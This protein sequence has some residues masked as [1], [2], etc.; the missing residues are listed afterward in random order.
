MTATS[1]TKLF[2]IILVLALYMD[3]FSVAPQQLAQELSVPTQRYVAVS[4]S[5]GQRI[6]SLVGMFFVAVDT[7]WCGRGQRCV[8]IG[9][10]MAPQDPARVPSKPKAGPCTTLDHRD[11]HHA[12][13]KACHRQ[14]RELAPALR[15]RCPCMH[16]V[17]RLERYIPHIQ[18]NF[19]QARF[20]LGPCCLH[21]AISTTL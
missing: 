18:W 13:R 15:T 11:L 10:A 20:H 7:A 14:R 4:L 16:V 9:Q 19:V 1:D 21:R 17:V 6:V 12:I 8:A 2:A 3:N 5:Q